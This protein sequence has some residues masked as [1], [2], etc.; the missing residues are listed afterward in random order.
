MSLPVLAS[1]FVRVFAP[2]AL[3]RLCSRPYPK[4][5]ETPRKKSSRSTAKGPNRRTLGTAEYREPSLSV[6]A[7]VAAVAWIALQ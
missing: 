5:S 4:Q 2:T 3:D 1:V 7:S 6:V